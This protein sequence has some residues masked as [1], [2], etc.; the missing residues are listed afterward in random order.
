MQNIFIK[1]S[2]VFIWV[3]SLNVFAQQGV[4]VISLTVDDNTPW[5]VHAPGMAWTVDVTPSLAVDTINDL[6]QGIDP[7]LTYQWFDHL[8]NPLGEKTTV[9]SDIIKNGETFHV[10]SPANPQIGWYGLRFVCDNPAAI[11]K[12]YFPKEPRTWGFA[13][14]ELH[15]STYRTANLANNFGLTHNNADDPYIGGID[16]NM[17]A[18]T[19][20]AAMQTKA[21]S[22]WNQGLWSMP[23]IGNRYPWSS[24]RTED[25][26][27]F[28][29]VPDEKHLADL[30]EFAKNISAI[31]YVRMWE[32]GLEE[33]LGG[34]YFGGKEKENYYMINT[35]PK[36][37][38]AASEGFAEG[39][40]LRTD[41]GK[42]QICYQIAEP[43][44]RR[45]DVTRFLESEAAQYVD[46]LSLHPYQWPS[47]PDPDYWMQDMMDFVHRE[48]ART[49]NSH[50]EIWFT[51][52]GAPEH[53]AYRDPDG[54]PK[55]DQYFGYNGDEWNTQGGGVQNNGV[56]SR[57]YATYVSKLL[58]LMFNKGVT[59]A[60]WYCYKDRSSNRSYPEDW[61]GMIDYLR[62]PKP[63]YLAF[64]ESQEHLMAAE[65]KGLFRIGN[66]LVSSYKKADNN[67]FVMWLE[68]DDQGLGAY[69]PA[70]WKDFEGWSYENINK[71]P[72][73]VTWEQLGI[74]GA[75]VRA[76]NMLGT[77]IEISDGV[78]VGVDPVYVIAIDVKP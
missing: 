39:N 60:S 24:I 72:Q 5:H 28:M 16:K 65:P 33:N 35:L 40:L 74:A 11:L 14:M 26:S 56:P 61:F 36:L 7:R 38:K 41:R 17:S 78:T 30:K 32:F 69:D 15:S 13:V 71:T 31:N 48:I 6:L 54:D 67:V 47:F 66:V 18:N 70:R 20:Y 76:V 52:V 49:G 46:V 62:F 10:N 59:G 53:G 25:G 3:F 75:P 51:E 45:A 22:L 63:A 34:N 23:L 9:D 1:L 77:P 27:G 21:N 57:F 68:Q 55:K 43:N 37:L 12:D 44:G 42:A 8:G 64:H 19:D 73:F 58:A 2:F 29:H 50:L 4:T